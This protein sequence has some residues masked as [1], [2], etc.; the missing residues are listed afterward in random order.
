MILSS[1]RA[2]LACFLA[3]SALLSSGCRRGTSN[4]APVSGEVFVQGQPA[5]GA[6]VIFYP[7]AMLQADSMPAGPAGGQGASEAGLPS[8]VAA[9]PRL[10]SQAGP[11]HW[12]FPSATVGADGSFQLTTVSAGDG[13]PPGEYQV[14]VIWSDTYREEGDLVSGP[15]RLGGRYA[16]PAASGLKATVGPGKNQLPRF[17]LE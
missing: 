2:V 11:P 15:D 12:Q 4:L 5:A 14:S 16:D 9:S 7:A 3:A 8:T 1:R 17:D 10:R 6:T 13:A